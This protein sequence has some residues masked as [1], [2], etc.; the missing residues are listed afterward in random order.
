MVVEP[1]HPDHLPEPRSGRNTAAVA[2]AGGVL[3]AGFVALGLLGRF[4]STDEAA[5]TST[6]TTTIPLSQP[7]LLEDFSVTDIETGIGFDWTMGISLEGMWPISL[8]EYQDSIYLFTVPSESLVGAARRLE[9]WRS[10]DGSSWDRVG[11]VGQGAGLGEVTTTNLGLATTG[12]RPDGTGVVWTTSDG[13]EWE[14]RPLPSPG[15]TSTFFNVTP[16]SVAGTQDRIVVAGDR[17]LNVARV[18][19]DQ[20][21]PGLDEAYY[22]PVWTGPPWGVAV[23]GPL[24]IL[25]FWVSAEDL[26]L[27]EEEIASLV[28][29]QNQ[30]QATVWSSVDGWEWTSATLDG[31]LIQLLS[32]PEDELMAVIHDTQ[33]R[34]LTSSDGMTWTALEPTWW[35]FGPVAR[36]EG[37]LIRAGTDDLL[38]WDDGP[39]WESFGVRE[40]LPE[41]LGWW[42]HSVAAGPAGIA[43]VA[44]TRQFD[45]VGPTVEPLVIESGDYTL[46]VDETRN[47]LTVS[48]GEASVDWIL[49]SGQVHEGIEIDFV[50]RTMSF[51]LPETEEAATF[52][53]DELETA[54]AA[55]AREN[56]FYSRGSHSVLLFSQDGEEWSLADLGPAVGEHGW[57]EEMLVTDTSVIA[58]V[59]RGTSTEV[60]MGVPVPNVAHR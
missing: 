14:E 49:Y 16:R 24:G 19:G 60:W 2:L 46:T 55:W 38:Y 3:L 35:E 45:P 53:F 48:H 52:T 10:P 4:D 15:N 41:F 21:P 47:Q 33:T 37:G 32:T 17:S 43:A 12:I 6:T 11:V 20:M 56:F 36:W 44:V 40:L 28:E 13:R 50:R 42:L 18:L 34:L 31:W 30:R 25:V 54:Q 51:H 26:G 57:I 27:D 9:I 39:Y 8:V 22:Y 1:D 23:Y 59:N 58:A 5:V 29:S 7:F